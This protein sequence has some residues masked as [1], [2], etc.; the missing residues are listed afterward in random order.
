MLQDD[1]DNVT[2]AAESAGT[3]IPTSTTPSTNLLDP[4]Q[5][6]LPHNV[7]ALYL[8]PLRRTPTH[9]LP[10]CDLQLRSFSTRQLTLAADFA[11]R[12]AYYLGLPAKGPVPLPR[13]TERWT[14]PRSNF[15]HK[16]SQENFERVTVRRLVQIQD[17]DPEVVRAWLGFLMKY[18]V[19]GV[20][21][22]ANVWE[23][24]GVGE[25]KGVEEVVREV[26]ADME[27]RWELFGRLGKGVVPE[28]VASGSADEAVVN[29]LG[30]QLG[31]LQT[32]HESGRMASG[33]GADAKEAGSI[34]TSGGESEQILPSG[35][36]LSKEASGESSAVAIAEPPKVAATNTAEPSEGR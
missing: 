19:S 36:P 34:S 30:E 3:P 9:G 7:A 33:E 27:G 22:K 16:K 12:A 8:R 31:G 35:T 15:V 6:R 28:R 13:R 4:S 26:E 29:A 11:L 20:G 23:H 10:V 14:V 2:Q 25:R 5:P 1:F 18:T 21:M 32:G 24:E 17:G